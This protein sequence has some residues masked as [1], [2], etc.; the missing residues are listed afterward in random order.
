MNLTPEQQTV[1]R[2][3][4]LK[5]VAG[6]PALAERYLAI[7]GEVLAVF[8]LDGSSRPRIMGRASGATVEV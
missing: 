2:R 1:G 4:F 7:H 5:A 6:V 8:S 3:N